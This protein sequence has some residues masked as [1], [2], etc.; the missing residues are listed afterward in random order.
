MKL[1]N[2]QILNFVN[3]A[4]TAKKLP[5]KLAYGISVNLKSIESALVAYNKQREELIE[6]Y[7]KKDDDGN[8]LVENNYYVFEDKTGWDESIAELLEAEAEVSITQVAEKALEKCDNPEFDTLTVTEL[9]AI[10]FMI[11]QQA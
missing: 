2:Q 1:T 11:K 9:S 8:P 5:V 3:S 4:I 6:K 10:Q 7:V